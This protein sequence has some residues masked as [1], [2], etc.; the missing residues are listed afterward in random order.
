[1]KIKFSLNYT[2]WL[3]SRNAIIYLVIF[4]SGCAKPE[5]SKTALLHDLFIR[6][7]VDFPID[8][9][10]II[11][12]SKFGCHTCFDI[13]TTYIEKKWSSKN[14]IFILPFTTQKEINIQYSAN[15]LKSKSVIIDKH[16]DAIELEIVRENTVILFIEKNQVTRQ[17]VLTPDNIESEL[18][19]L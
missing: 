5:N 13:V 10:A 1:M 2:K 6:I 3:K 7:G 9:K 18:K 4:L 12:Q 15:V 17:V 8:R 14:I 16:N 11:I 19:Q